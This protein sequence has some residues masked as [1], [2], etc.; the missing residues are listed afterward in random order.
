MSRTA[1]ASPQ[2][3]ARDAA[4]AV[5]TGGIR[6]D[7]AHET[8]QIIT[9]SPDTV[10]RKLKDV[11]DTVDPASFIIWGREGPISHDSASRCIDLLGQEVIPAIKEYQ[12]NGS[13]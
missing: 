9:G 10:I 6:Y 7:E 13:R 5:T 2:E 4:R 12:A 1:A 11:I 8:Y 3:A